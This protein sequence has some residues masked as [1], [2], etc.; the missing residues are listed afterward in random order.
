MINCEFKNWLMLEAE[1]MPLDQVEDSCKTTCPD[2]TVIWLI[3]LE[4]N[5]EQYKNL[6]PEEVEKINYFVKDY[7]GGKYIEGLESGKKNNFKFKSEIYDKVIDIIPQESE[8]NS[9]S[10]VK[11]L[12]GGSISVRPRKITQSEEFGNYVPISEKITIPSEIINK[13]LAVG[14]CALTCLH[15]SGGHV[16]AKTVGGYKKT[17]LFHTNQD[18]FYN[19]TL[20]DY[21]KN[22]LKA[23]YEKCLGTDPAKDID[24]YAVR[25]N[26]TTDIRHFDKKFILDQS[27]IYKI[28]KSINKYNS[29]SQTKFN[30]INLSFKEPVNFFDV[31]NQMWKKA[32]KNTNCNF[33]PAFLKF[34]DYTAI[35]GLSDAYAKGKL[36]K[37]YHITFSAKEGN[38]KQIMNALANGIGVA[39]P[40]WIGGSKKTNKIGF[41]TM[42]YPSGFSTGIGYRII[43]GDQ[44]DARF[45]DKKIHKIHPKEGYII[46]LRAKGKL[47]D[48]QDFD[49]GFSERILLDVKYPTKDKLTEFAK[50]YNF[51]ILENSPNF[52]DAKND[53]MV[54]TNSHLNPRFNPNDPAIN[55]IILEQIIYT[56]RRSDVL[57]NNLGKLGGRDFYH[58]QE[59][60][61]M[62][63]LINVKDLDHD[64]LHNIAGTSAKTDKGVAKQTYS[65]SSAKVEKGEQFKVKT[66]QTNMLPHSS[67]TALR[68]KLD[69]LKDQKFKDKQLNTNLA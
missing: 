11:P 16:D 21:F 49:S 17:Y 67:F 27:T 14:G 42:W 33:S 41:P 34:Y 68:N 10:G 58:A 22:A 29:K 44:Y 57:V 25:L 53:F 7:D 38:L 43:D 1:R 24:H 61:G 66:N 64:D 12:S 59:D 35:S 19:N 2:A 6:L 26:G 28:N 39:L 9:K 23:L 69:Y 18:L 51:K 45:L 56:L 60:R 52:E 54:M 62:E 47:E 31:F 65:G 37:N 4:E 20:E 8:A 15:L 46:G 32:T 63:R 48:V 36:P 50:R 30:T 3:K 13:I 55:K 40:I 5:W